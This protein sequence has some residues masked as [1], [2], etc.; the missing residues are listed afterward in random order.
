M[1]RRLFALT[2][3]MVTGFGILI[4]EQAMPET[5]AAMIGR[6]PAVQEAQPEDPF[7]SFLEE[8]AAEPTVIMASPAVEAAVLPPETVQRLYSLSWM[9]AHRPSSS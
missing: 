9:I 1:S 7:A 6:A 8:S 5:E 3:I 4:T 2:V